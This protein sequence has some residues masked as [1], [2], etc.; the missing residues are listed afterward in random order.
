MCFISTRAWSVSKSS[1]PLRLPRRPDGKSGK[2]KS[3]E[4]EGLN[5]RG[6]GCITQPRPFL[7]LHA[8]RA[9]LDAGRN[10]KRP[11][12]L[13]NR[14]GRV[15]HTLGESPGA[16]GAAGTEKR[17]AK[18]ATTTTSMFSKHFFSSASV[19]FLITS[20]ALGAWRASR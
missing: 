13:M 11:D 10:A 15:N 4:D 7:F 14:C 19:H 2:E 6:R 18:Y 20:P 1:K 5:A 16:Y 12:G 9:G 8:Q 3:G 17:V